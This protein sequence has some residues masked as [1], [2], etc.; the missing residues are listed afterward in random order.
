MS[1]PSASKKKPLNLGKFKPA[2][3][4]EPS[5]APAEGEGET[6]FIR[7]ATAK[8][9]ETKF[10]AGELETEEFGLPLKEMLGVITY[11]YARGYFNSGEIAALMK[12]D[13]E[14]RKSLGKKLPDEA[15]VR[16]FRRKYANEI[17]DA[18]ETLYRAF[19]PGP[20]PELPKV[21]SSSQTTIAHKQAS[22]RVHDAMWTDNNMPGHP[23]MD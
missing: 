2:A 16:K 10:A 6:M 17:E 4:N 8:A 13:P 1:K 18:L 15:A 3:K 19:P 14:L 7:R 9:A 12:Q 22:Y 5:A 20:T 23:F 21:E 11:C